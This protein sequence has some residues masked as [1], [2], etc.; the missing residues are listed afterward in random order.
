[1]TTIEILRAAKALIDEPGKWTKNTEARD[2]GGEPTY[3][4]GVDAC[5]FC[6]VGA[7]NRAARR[8]DERVL[9]MNAIRPV[10]WP[11]LDRW[12]DH[13]E[14]THHEVMTRFDETIALLEGKS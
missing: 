2:R 11:S 4:D 6:M 7:I 9:A 14:R 3:P 5:S 8:P 12:N 10:G 13:R 1:M